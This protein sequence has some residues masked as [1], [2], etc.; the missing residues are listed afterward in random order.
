ME[1]CYCEKATEN[2]NK[3]VAVKKIDENTAWKKNGL[4][5]NIWR[6]KV[7]PYLHGSYIEKEEKSKHEEGCVCPL[8]FRLICGECLPL[9]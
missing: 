8:C 6:K 4:A 2:I 5:C 7:K 1:I 3:I 9:N